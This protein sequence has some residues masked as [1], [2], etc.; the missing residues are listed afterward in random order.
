[1]SD[2]INQ[3]HIESA[4]NFVKSVN[5]CI[6]QVKQPHFNIAYYLN[7]AKQLGHAETLG[8]KDIFELSEAEFG[9]KSTSTKNYIAVAYDF[10]QGDKLRDKY[11]EFSFT[12]LVEMLSIDYWERSLIKPAMTI[13]QIREW[14]AS[15]RT[16]TLN[17][18]SKRMYGDLSATE[19]IAYDT[20]N[21]ENQIR[22]DKSQSTDQIENDKIEPV[23][24]L[25]TFEKEITVVSK[26]IGF[27]KSKLLNF[28]NKEQ[29]QAFINS[30]ADWGVWLS[31]PE[32]NL[33][34]Y[35]YKFNNGDELVVSCF[36]YYTEWGAEIKYH[37]SKK[38]HLITSVKTEFDLTGI[39]ETYLIDYLTEKRNEI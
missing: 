8:Y 33:T 10:M 37:S 13:K 32:I 7:Q 30:Y 35:K 34:C 4:Q 38:Y 19:K 31:V 39:A 20:K 28:K 11:S 14:K 6:K 12:Q 21:K 9:F 2:S 36:G 27:I 3:V 1:M 18:G 24:D 17:D 26:V 23:P 25:N 15:K 5:E 16:V 29:R 22:S